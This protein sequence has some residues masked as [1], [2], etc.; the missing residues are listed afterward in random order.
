MLKTYS[1]KEEIRRGFSDLGGCIIPL[2][3][4]IVVLKTALY[5]GC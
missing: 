5:T 2:N 3:P 4:N 1:G